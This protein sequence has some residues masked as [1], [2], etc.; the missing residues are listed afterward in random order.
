MYFTQ[1]GFDLIMSFLF[2]SISVE[3]KYLDLRAE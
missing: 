1:N 3:E 2:H